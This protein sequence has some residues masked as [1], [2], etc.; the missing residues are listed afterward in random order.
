[1]TKPQFIFTQFKNSFSVHVENLEQLEVEQIQA[2][3]TFVEKRN[4]VFDFTNYTFAIQKILEFDDFTI[5]LKHANIDATC[6]EVRLTKAQSAKVEFGKYKGMSYCD[7]PDSYIL[8]LKSNYR[9]KERD[10]IDAEI[11]SRNL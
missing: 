6:R 9:G 7:L 1:M 8:W 5:L 2:I 10:I 11:Q 4:G 3:Q